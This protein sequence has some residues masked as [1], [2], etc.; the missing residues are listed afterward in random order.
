MGH[1]GAI[2]TLPTFTALDSSTVLSGHRRG[3]S[4]QLDETYFSGQRRATDA[5]DDTPEASTTTSR[6]QRVRDLRKSR[7]I[8]SSIEVNVDSFTEEGL[9]NA[10]TQF[11]QEL[12]NI[13]EI[14]HLKRQFPG[15]CFVVPEWL[16][17]EDRLHY[18]ARVYFFQDDDSTTPKDVMRENIDAILSD[19]FQEF[20]RYQG[21]LHG[22][23][24]CCIDFYHE[25]S[26]NAPSPEWRSI[27]PF[28]DRINDV[29]LGNGISVSIDDVLPKFS[30]WYDRYAFFAREFFPE[31]GCETAL[32]QGEAIFDSLTSEYP[33]PL[34]EDYF[35]LNFGYNFLVARAVHT[36]GTHRPPPGELGEEH[37]MFYLPLRELLTIPRYS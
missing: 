23:P 9:W 18:G 12:Q 7:D 5:F 36:G 3:T 16:R 25:R 37:L 15:Q 22:Y 24:N 30:G 11:H 14:N 1:Q 33:T 21:Q 10:S 32:M 2:T 13:P 29:A 31:P 4:I 34:V 8:Y 27:E 17:T 26:S 6:K 20:E 28:A 35:R 19:S